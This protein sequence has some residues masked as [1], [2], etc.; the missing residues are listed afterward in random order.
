MPKLKFQNPWDTTP[1][2]EPS[3]EGMGADAPRKPRT[4][5]DELDAPP[6]RTMKIEAKGY[7]GFT[8]RNVDTRTDAVLAV[9]DWCIPRL[10]A[11]D[12][13]LT[14]YGIAVTQLA[15]RPVQG[16]FV[17]RGW[18]GWTLIIPEVRSS[19]EGLLQLTQ[20]LLELARGPHGKA[21]QDHGII[22]YRL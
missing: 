10:A 18:D 6:P 5:I 1:A 14:Q 22:P 20:A 2:P 21:L 7:G 3:A 15:E 17:R 9:L 12:E 11:I 19:E 8:V 16:F 4:A 13:V